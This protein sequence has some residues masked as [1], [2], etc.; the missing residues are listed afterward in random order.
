LIYN[1]F[2]HVAPNHHSHGYWRHPDGQG[3]LDIKCL[4]RWL[5]LARTVERGRF[6]TVFLTD[7]VGVYDKFRGNGDTS[8]RSAMQFPS[9][10][11]ASLVSALAAV[12]EH[13]DFAG[14]MSTLDHLTD[15]RVAWNIVTSYLDNPARNFGHE[16]LEEHDERYRRAARSR[17]WRHFGARESARSFTARYTD[18]KNCRASLHQSARNSS[19]SSRQS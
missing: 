2:T 19:P 13:V 6:D 4:Q 3:Q 12:T 1:A 7:V 8:I 9:L 18:Q 15:G 14:K 11:P 10:D 16:A 5:D 17:A